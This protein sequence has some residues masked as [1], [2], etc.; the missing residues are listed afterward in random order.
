MRRYIESRIRHLNPVWRNRLAAKVSYFFVRAGFDR[1][2]IA[3]IEREINSRQRRGDVERNI[4]LVSGY[5]HHVSTDLIRHVAVSSYTIRPDYYA[6]DFAR[7]QEMASHT[8]GY[9]RHRNV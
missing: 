8:I 1:N 9:Q 6:I 5:S 3:R 7:L 4:V 2:L